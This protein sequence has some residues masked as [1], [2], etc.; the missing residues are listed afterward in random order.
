MKLMRFL[1]LLLLVFL[2]SA[3]APVVKNPVPLPSLAQHQQPAVK[4]Y[5]IQAS[6]QLEVKF[7]Y[8]PELNEQVIVRPD[9]RISLQLAN[10]VMVAGLTP[11]EL[12][13]QLRKKYAAEIEKPEITV[14]VRSFTSQRVFVDGEV[15][16]AGLIALT[17]PMT[18]LQSISQAGGIR[19]TALLKGV[20]VIRRA[21]ENKL[22]AMQLNLENALDNSDMTQDI[23]LVPNDIVY[24]PKST[25]AN[26]DVWV[27]QYIR[28]LLPFSTGITYGINTSIIY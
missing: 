13:D 21:S 3:C 23:S 6:D 4:E 11:A 24:V 28:R 20:I 18:V 25:I 27:D 9:G 14:I 19:D 12:T 1:K 15:N 7:F 16:K 10:D 5:R 2:V 26:I 17:E 22:V 8:N